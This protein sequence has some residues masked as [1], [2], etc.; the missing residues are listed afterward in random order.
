MSEQSILPDYAAIVSDFIEQ[1]CP[2]FFTNTDSHEV[3]LTQLQVSAELKKLNA[4]Q[5][6]KLTL[7]C[8]DLLCAR[9]DFTSN[10]LAN[11]DLLA[12]GREDYSTKMYIPTYASFIRKA[13]INRSPQ[14]GPAVITQYLLKYLLKLKLTLSNEELI[15]LFESAKQLVPCDGGEKSPTIYAGDWAIK[16]I[17]NQLSSNIKTNGLSDEIIEFINNYLSWRYF[18]TN[19]KAILAM[20][21][22]LFGLVN[23]GGSAMPLFELADDDV[24]ADTIKNLIKVAAPPERDMLYRMLELSSG[25]KAG[26]PTAA[27]LEKSKGIIETNKDF[28]R[29]SMHKILKQ[30]CD[31]E[32]IEEAG[33]DGYTYHI[34]ID[35]D[36]IPIIKGLVWSSVQF[37][38]ETMIDLLTKLAEKS[39]KKIPGQG[40]M[41]VIVGNACL[42]T[43]A[44]SKGLHGISQLSRLKYFIKQTNAKKIID[45]YLQEEAEKRGIKAYE[46]EEI[47]VPDFGLQLGSREDEF[48]GYKL[49]LN[50]V[51]PGKTSLQWL[52]PE[53][54]AQKT[55]PALIAKSK[56]L[57]DK[58]KTVQETNKQIQ[59]FSSAQKERIDRCYV[60]DRVWDYETFREYYID[61]GLVGPIAAKLI[62]NF[63]NGDQWEAAMLIDSEWLAADGSA[64]SPPDRSTKVQLWHP[65]SCTETEIVQWRARVNELEIRQPFKQAY[66]EVYL[67][68]DA[69]VIT[70]SYSNR[71]AAH[72][73]KQRQFKG[74]TAGRS[75]KYSLINEYYHGSVARPAC[76]RV[77]AYHLTAEFGINEVYVEDGNEPDG[78]NR[79]ISTDQVKFIKDDGEVLDLVDV[80]DLVFSEIMRD[81]DL[82]VGVCSVGN[83]PE[84]SDT[85]V[86]QFSNYWEGYS[87]GD[88]NEMAKT[89]KSVLEMLVPKLKIRDQLRFDGKFLRVQ[90]KLREYKIHIGSSN[91]LMEPND[92]Y[93]CIVPSRASETK[94]D[95]MY[96]PFEGDRGLSLVLSKAV[97]LADDHKIKD[98]TIISQI[99][100]EN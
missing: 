87:F 55:K 78:V 10:D 67:L 58:L 29:E 69:E 48:D 18:K 1:S 3:K 46:I 28:F 40:P 35:G 90:G 34:F 94:A 89:R 52:T 9:K 88:L 85:G 79:Y 83:D 16:R 95:K 86:E 43:L 63:S 25:A 54:K 71:M 19:G 23:E 6:A 84:W 99:S 59:K 31:A 8:M 53:G 2:M 100:R 60:E 24:I 66:R 37:H 45:S 13:A 65:I 61:H 11:G 39:F 22:Q 49:Q 74:I 97:L 81:V 36:N 33:D 20:K 44:N 76:L 72:L 42:Y 12:R 7:Y 27:F 50:L 92:Q 96:L 75:W 15:I 57:S 70:K 91:I 32:P 47:A 93:L 80:P 14:L 73:L 30:L 98:S 56:K 41:C 64:I 77:P 17:I 21:A 5:K 82:F 62:W 51:S 68:T 4:E 26:K 38:D